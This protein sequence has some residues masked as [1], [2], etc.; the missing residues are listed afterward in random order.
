MRDTYDAVYTRWLNDQRRGEIGAR[1]NRRRGFFQGRVRR[2]A[3][4]K[5][6]SGKILRGTIKKI[7]DGSI[8]KCRL[9]STSAD[10]R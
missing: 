8:I 2:Q 1:E 6:R 4:T 9:T 5:T 10:P 3:A 7:A